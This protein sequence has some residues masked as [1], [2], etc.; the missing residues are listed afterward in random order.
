MVSE[1]R[2]IMRFVDNET[3][4][5]GAPCCQAGEFSWVCV[6]GDG[7][8][9]IAQCATG[10]Q[11]HPAPE[12]N[13]TLGLT[14]LLK[15]ATIHTHTL[16]MLLYMR[17]LKILRSAISTTFSGPKKSDYC[18]ALSFIRFFQIFFSDFFKSET[19]LYRYCGISPTE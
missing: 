5:P 1:I 2:L 11:P 14:R 7:W 13:L 10:V 15:P 4:W 6:W 9:L 16:H 19:L 3:W 12:S 18:H 8:S 17:G